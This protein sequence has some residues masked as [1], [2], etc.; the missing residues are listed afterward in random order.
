MNFKILPVLFAL[1]ACALWPQGVVLCMGDEG[2][3]EVELSG[4]GCCPSE[5][6]DCA[7][8]VDFDSPEQ[9]IVRVAGTLAPPSISAADLLPPVASGAKWTGSSVPLYPPRESA[10]EGVVLLV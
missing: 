9:K 5:T 1:L 4:S 6:D 8:C 7:D 2:H 3:V 10:L